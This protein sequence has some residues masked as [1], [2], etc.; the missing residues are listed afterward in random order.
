MQFHWPGFDSFQKLSAEETAELASRMAEL[1][2]AGLP[3]GDGLRA[4]ADELSGRRLRRVLRTLA[5]Q[6]DSGVDLAVAIESQSARLSVCLRGLVLAGLRSGRLAETLEEYVDLQRS[7]AELRRRLWTSLAYP[8]ILLVFLALLAVVARFYIVEQFTKMYKEFGMALPAVTKICLYNSWS[9]VWGLVFLVCAFS[10]IPL[11]LAVAPGVPW[12]W[13][14]LHKLPMIGPLLRWTHLAQFCRLMALLLEQD[15]P[16]PDALRLA[17]AGLHDADLAHGCRRLAEDVDSGRA[18]YESM[19]ARR[20]FPASLIPVMEWGQRAPALPDAFR[21]AAEMFE[22]R[23]HSQGSLLEAILLPI[24]FLVITGYVGM[25]VVSLFLPLIVCIECLSG[26]GYGGYGYGY[27]GGVLN[28]QGPLTALAIFAPILLGIAVLVSQ[29]LISGPRDKLRDNV[30]NLTLTVTGWVLIAV[31]LA[32]SF[33]SLFVMIWIPW[34]IIAVVVLIETV[35]KQR[36]SQ[37][38]A[39]LWLLAVSAERFMPLVP[40]IEAFARERGGFFGR[41]AKRLAEMLASGVPLPAALDACRNVLP[42][43]AL[44]MI[45]IGWQ[46][47]ALAPALRE[48]ATVSGQHHG[49]WTS[50]VGKLT[51]L[52]LMPLFGFGILSFVMLWIVPKFGKMFREFGIELPW[53]MRQLTA[54]ATALVNYW[55]LFFPFWFAVVLLL[56]YAGLRHYGLIRWNLPGMGWLARRLDSANVMD[57]LAIVAGQQRPLLDGVAGLARSYPTAG[58]RW[59]LCRAADDIETGTDWAESLQRRGLIR[60]T[61]LAILQAAQRAGNLPWALQEMAQ[62]NRRRFAYRLQ[63]AAQTAFPVVVIF[64]GAMVAFIVVALFL[65]LVTLIQ[66]LS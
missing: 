47:G 51:Y 39:L 52:I 26:G 60:R 23:T 37:Q 28:E 14:M 25:F 49:L 8:F 55:F 36:V 29:R 40:A 16:L 46:S 24:I 35:R 38:Y 59:R 5:D 33:I 56:C 12:M 61:D 57:A 58:I 45:R 22:G 6:L 3:L 13:P 1:T 62:S 11:V 4:L 32:G 42:R 2:R 41:R 44:P 34:W 65:P 66:S 18:L 20:Q 48:A 17:A 63:A 10:A 43:S 21:A 9:A 19:A 31:G 53:M 7:Q 15:V 54:A 50:L 27:G 30:V 64:F